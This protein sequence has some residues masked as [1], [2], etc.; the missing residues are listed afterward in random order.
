MPKFWMGFGGRTKQR[1]CALE[2]SRMNFTTLLGFIAGLLQFVVAGYALRLNRQFGTMRVGW[3]L[4]W[5]FLLLACLHLMQSMMHSGPGTEYVIKI[6]VMNVF[7]SLLLLIGMVHLQA[8]LKERIRVE[9]EELKMRGEL[10]LEVKKKTMFLT[11]A[12]EE[13]QAE[14]DERR[15]VESEAQSTRGELNAVSRRAETALLA[16][17]VLERVGE[18]LKSV[19][20]S[21]SLVSDQMKQSRIENVVRVGALIREHAADLGAFLTGDARGQKL[22]TYIA[23]LAEHLATEQTGVL[24]ELDALRT[25]LEKIQ[26]MQHGYLKMAGE[27][28]PEKP[29]E[30]V[31]PAPAAPTVQ[32]MDAAAAA[33]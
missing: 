26:T 8:M 3:S 29:A 17:N 30:P 22:P 31:E 15:R 14:I 13:L 33:A 7:I 21:A 28:L 5:A 4:F 9:R 16:A 32:P 2:R 12:L 25:N 24:N 6:D 10:E 27:V 11:R 1:N 18:M 20:A 23:Q 19:N